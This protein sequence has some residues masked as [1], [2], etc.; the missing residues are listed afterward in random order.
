MCRSIPSCS[1]EKGMWNLHM[2]YLSGLGEPSCLFSK[3]VIGVTAWMAV[4]FSLMATAWQSKN[5]DIV[6]MLK[7]MKR[8]QVWPQNLNHYH[9]S[10]LESTAVR[11]ST[12]M[13]TVREC[14]LPLGCQSSKSVWRCCSQCRSTETENQYIYVRTH[15][16]YQC[17]RSLPSEPKVSNRR[18]KSVLTAPLL[19]S[20]KSIT[21]SYSFLLSAWRIIDLGTH[22]KRPV[23]S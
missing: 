2:T 12:V 21:S 4:W 6:K 11:H 8:N 5:M 22:H 9:S 7:I 14:W 19:F 23:N 3:L 10:Q 18:P 1:N 15:P 20:N 17:L 16:F 13:C